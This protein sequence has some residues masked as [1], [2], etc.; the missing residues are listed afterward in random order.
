MTSRELAEETLKNMLQAAGLPIRASYRSGEVCD[1][2]GIGVATFWRLLNQCERDE[3]GNL[4]RPDCLDSFMLKL[5]R[6]VSYGEL[7]DFLTRNNGY[8]RQN[9]IHPDQMTLFT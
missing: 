9:A 6:R 7:I 1:I 8:Q 3:R 2:L 5:H 4:K